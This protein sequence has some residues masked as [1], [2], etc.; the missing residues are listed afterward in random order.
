[1]A[2][3]VV[4]DSGTLGLA[5]RNRNHST[6]AP[7]HK[8]MDAILVRGTDI[9]FA[10]SDIAVVP[11]ERHERDLA[12]R[13]DGIREKPPIWVGHGCE[14]ARQ[15]DVSLNEFEFRHAHACQADGERERVG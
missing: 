3:Y 13:R 4:L 8:W 6:A 15:F 9:R 12:F 11:K 1:M 2:E 10:R 14:G 7:F 5:C